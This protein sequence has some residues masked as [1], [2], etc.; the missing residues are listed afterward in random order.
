MK[1]RS[2]ITLKKAA[3]LH[4]PRFGEI[5]VEM[6]FITAEQL[7][8]ALSEQVDNYFSHKPYRLIGAIFLKKGWMTMAQIE[9]VL[10]KYLKHVRVSRELSKSRKN[11]NC[12]VTT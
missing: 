5:A 1:S 8:E 7:K 4:C 9:I 11:N 6:G 3:N 2:R 12:K 10:H